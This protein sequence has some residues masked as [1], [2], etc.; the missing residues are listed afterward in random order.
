MRSPATGLLRG[1]EVE[2]MAGRAPN[3]PRK[4]KLEPGATTLAAHLVYVLDRNRTPLLFVNFYPVNGCDSRWRDLQTCS[5][6]EQREL[7][8]M[9]GPFLHDQSLTVLSTCSRGEPSVASSVIRDGPEQ[10]KSRQPALPGEATDPTIYDHRCPVARALYGIA[11]SCAGGVS[12]NANR[13][14]MSH[15]GQFWPH[16]NGGVTN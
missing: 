6:A 16:V 8:W 5:S 14:A 4:F 13:H 1:N 3:E 10:P 11:R 12:H 7:A 15:G 2:L 9:S